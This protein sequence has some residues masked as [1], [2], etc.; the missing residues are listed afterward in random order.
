MRRKPSLKFIKADFLPLGLGPHQLWLSCEGSDSAIQAALIQSKIL[1][2]RYRDDVL[3]SKFDNRKSG[4]CSL[5]NCNNFPGDVV[6]Y[7]SG[8]CPALA[9]VQNLTLERCLENLSSTPMLIPLVVS[10]LQSSSEDWSKF[11]LDPS[12]NCHVIPIQQDFG[13][14]AIWPLFRFSRAMIWCMHQHRMKLM[15]SD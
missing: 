11:I 10:A 15:S 14:Q 2:G 9:P 1:T 5:P 8:S 6:H 3:L 13:P 12:T 7:L 4:R